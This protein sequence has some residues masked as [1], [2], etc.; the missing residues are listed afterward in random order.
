[1][2]LSVIVPIKPDTGRRDL[3]W[4]KVRQRYQRFHP[5]L[6]L[7]IGEDFSEPFCKAKAINQAAKIA[8][9]DALLIADSDVI[10]PPDLIPRLME[11]IENYPWVIPFKRGVR[12]NEAASNRLLE[13]DLPEPLIYF[14]DEVEEVI[15]HPGALLCAMMRTSFAAVSGVD[16]RFKGW[17]FT[18]TTFALTLN[19]ICGQPFQMDG[20]IYHIYHPKAEPQGNNNLLLWARYVETQ[21][22]METMRK[23]IEERFSGN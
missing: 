4:S 5:D 7:C 21:D 13:Q 3:I 2:K 16:E 8:T 17:G 18:D 1:M 22:N 23:I 6:E 9:G 19:V 12:L 20:D 15:T 11:C 10:F 14:E